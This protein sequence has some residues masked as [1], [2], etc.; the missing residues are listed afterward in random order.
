[1]PQPNL[2]TKIYSI[3]KP[4]LGLVLNEP[5]SILNPR[6][7]TAC[8]N[9]MFANGVAKKRT[10]YSDYGIGTITGIPLKLYKYNDKIH[11]NDR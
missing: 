4:S 1:M 3:Y 7:A 9:V 8:Q 6:A 11:N 10:G 5:T 2:R